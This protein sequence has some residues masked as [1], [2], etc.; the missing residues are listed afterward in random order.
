MGSQPIIVTPLSCWERRITDLPLV[1]LGIYQT[2]IKTVHL[3]MILVVIHRLMLKAVVAPCK[4][5]C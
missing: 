3:H 4:P 2:I 1:I 5:L